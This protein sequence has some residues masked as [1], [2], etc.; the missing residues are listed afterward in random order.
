MGRRAKVQGGGRRAALLA[1]AGGARASAAGSRT[2]Q[3]TL[4]QRPSH[5]LL[6]AGTVQSSRAA[7]ARNSCQGRA[8]ISAQR[9]WGRRLGDLRGPPPPSSVGVVPSDAWHSS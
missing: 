8:F 6:A 7:K 5:H 2:I 3:S 9:M 1:T 4:Q